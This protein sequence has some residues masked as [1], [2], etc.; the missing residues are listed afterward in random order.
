MYQIISLKIGE[1]FTVQKLYLQNQDEI[2]C[3][4]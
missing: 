1:N 2:K 3:P 4:N